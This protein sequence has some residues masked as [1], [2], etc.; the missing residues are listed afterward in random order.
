[1]QFLLWKCQGTLSKSS[2]DS[3]N[4]FKYRVI[5][6]IIGDYDSDTI[7]LTDNPLLVK[8]AVQNYGR[9]QVPTCFVSAQ[10]IKR[11]YTDEQKA[12]LD[13]KTSVNKIGEIVNLSQQLNSLYWHNINNGQ[14]FEE[15]QG[16]YED[17]CK[18]AVLS[19]IEI[20]ISLGI[21]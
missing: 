11:Y 12:D 17:I 16:L 8:R 20:K 4:P 5:E 3:L 19:N 13:V 2:R 10:K 6:G 15:N 18:L 1:M 9:F 7:L 21:Q 14:G